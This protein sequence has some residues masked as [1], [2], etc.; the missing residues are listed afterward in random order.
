M[1]EAKLK[2]KALELQKREQK[3]ILLDDE[4]RTKINEASRKI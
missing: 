4:I 2:L 3:L 1:L